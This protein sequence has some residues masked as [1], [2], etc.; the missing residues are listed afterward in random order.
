M[1]EGIAA[2]MQAIWPYA[3]VF[4]AGFGA[5]TLLPLPSEV[6]LVA[7]IK[8]GNSSMLGLV[9]AATAGNVGGS[10][11]NWWFGRSLR[12]FEGRRWFPFTPDAVARASATFQRWGLWTLLLAWVPVIGDPLTL[13]AGL[14]RVPL[15]AFVPLVTIGKAAR[16][17]AL[18][19]GVDLI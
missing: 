3:S 7:Q 6:V 2:L 4:V 5:A 10:L 15:M 1:M 17:L 9:V 13:V 12:H 19:F 11:V 14:L 16:Y 18:A 8:A